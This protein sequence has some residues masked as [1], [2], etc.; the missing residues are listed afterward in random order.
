M[1]GLRFLRVLRLMTTP[2]I[3]QYLNI[4]KTSNSIRL[5][6]LVSTLISI[7]F[8]AAG[9]VHLVK[10]LALG[11]WPTNALSMLPCTL[12]SARCCPF[13][14]H[15]AMFHCVVSTALMALNAV[16]IVVWRLSSSRLYCYTACF[17][18]NLC[19]Y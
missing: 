5:C 17:F 16:N 12:C 13:S 4:L 18:I 14:S 11:L 19:R 8:T 7:W 1:L 9:F 6:Q 3:L 15:V 10:V 2:D